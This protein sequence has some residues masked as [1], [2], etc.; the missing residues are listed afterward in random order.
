V[1]FNTYRKKRVFISSK[2][3][4]KYTY[5]RRELEILLE[6]TGLFDVYN[7]DEEGSSASDVGTQYLSELTG[8]DIAIFLIDNKDGVTD[9]VF[10]EHTRT[11]E[12]G[13]KRHYLFC[14]EE[15]RTPTT[16]QTEVMHY[17]KYEV[18]H[19]F[20]K[21]AEHAYTSVFQD[22]IDSY[23]R[24]EAPA[25]SSIPSI[26][27][28]KSDNAI[29]KSK[30]PG[31]LTTISKAGLGAPNSIKK[32]VW[33]ILIGNKAEP[34]KEEDSVESWLYSFLNA[35]LCL[36]P[37]NADT[38]HK[39]SDYVLQQHDDSLKGTISIRLQ[40]IKEYYEGKID[41]A[42][43]VER[44]AL[45][46]ALNN[47]DVP[48]WL[49]NDIAI[50]L[51]NLII[52]SERSKG[53]FF[54]AGD[55]G[56]KILDESKEPVYFPLLDRKIS[57]ANEEIV[58]RYEKHYSDS[59]FS[60]T[61]GDSLEPALDDFVDAF[62]IAI[63]YGSNTHVCLFVRN[64]V[65][66]LKMI[67][68]IYDDHLPAVQL[69]RFTCI[70]GNKLND[71]LDYIENTYHSDSELLNPDECKSILDSIK[72]YPLKFQRR[73]V[74]Y[75][76]LAKFSMYL[77]DDD[78]AD[79]CVEMIRD[80]IEWINDESRHRSLITNIVDFYYAIS[81]R[82]HIN[83]C[84]DFGIMLLKKT[85]GLYLNELAQKYRGL[86]Y[87]TADAEKLKKFTTLLLQ[88][89][90]EGKKYIDDH[91]FVRDLLVRIELSNEECASMIGTLLNE[92]APE[93]Y[94]D[95]YQIEMNLKKLNNGDTSVDLFPYI[96]G[97]LKSIK[98]ENQAAKQ[99][100]AIAG[101]DNYQIIL[102]ILRNWNPPLNGAQVN[103]II[104]TILP[105]L[106]N[107]AQS[108]RNKAKSCEIISLLSRQY[109]NL[110]DKKKIY[111]HLL[112]NRSDYMNYA[113]QFFSNDTITILEYAYNLM[114]LTFSTRDTGKIQELLFS[115]RQDQSYTL[116]QLLAITKE[117]LK[118]DKDQLI[119][120]ML[121]T[122]FLQFTLVASQNIDKNVQVQCV[123]VL[124]ELSKY[125]KTT[126]ASIRR[127]SKFMSSGNAYMRMVTIARVNDIDGNNEYVKAIRQKALNDHNYMV[128]KIA[129]ESEN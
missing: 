60:V 32:Y 129:L 113:D 83:D 122:S 54:T 81:Q 79:I 47:K 100:V 89:L 51:R 95:I 71:N 121:L 82:E 40:A 107:K 57:D 19:E 117:F 108:I 128:R 118:A 38:F 49:V 106:G 97:L 76:Y 14:D 127:L 68:N 115:V 77:N 28:V 15:N 42:V 61:I 12:A 112:D 56:Q 46:G 80:S 26:P 66:F 41:N 91:S 78:F 17:A 92:K 99:G 24:K 104:D 123:L 86:N 11:K 50:D 126:N 6:K 90:D 65:D 114:L 55:E 110:F 23:C 119:S 10:K 53:T 93:Y 70:D 85:N 98:K 1:E 111:Q 7:F 18:V 124:V 31:P 116:I 94:D 20:S 25:S 45:R 59:P 37:F 9:P 8:S 96:D 13:L 75:K 21:M 72:I 87:G 30:D 22:I 120:E 125:K 67:I 69:I 103:Q 43:D 35:V 52:D 73:S 16:L 5:V 74:L 105:V 36:Q 84:L 2:C 27:E 29:S 48:G 58:K 34:I 39:L 101:Y 33:N 109:G 62:W 88:G 3:G 64:M 102:N 44:N 4:G 63:I